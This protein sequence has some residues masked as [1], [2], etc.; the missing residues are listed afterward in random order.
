[1]L[2]VT[3]VIPCYN[4]AKFIREAIQSAL[5]QQYDG[6]LEILVG[7]DASTDDSREIAE[8][9]GGPVRV[10]CD[11]Q[12]GNRGM[13]AVRNRCIAAAS[14]PLIAF[15]DA[16][17]YWLDG[18]LRN[19]ANALEQSP[20]LGLV[21]DKGYDVSPTRQVICHRF[22]E[23]HAPR[24]TP[25]QLL[26]EQCFVPAAVMVRRSVFARVGLFDESLRNCAD[27]DMWLRVL[28]AFP[29]AHVPFYGYCYR[30]HPDQNSLSPRLW[31]AAQRVLDKARRRYRYRSSAIRQR[32]A[33]LAYR[34]S[35]IAIREKRYVR[36]ASL[37]LKAG[38]LDP[39]RALRELGSMARRIRRETRTGNHRARQECAAR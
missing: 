36:A 25:D 10:L 24:V 6:A 14:H 21:Y 13:S 19:L 15:L 39:L 1:M 17:D 38:V 34:F 9:I 26:L 30:C 27:H 16:D 23:P 22:P 32:S 12:G 7:E 29:A 37:L 31:T 18:H 20:E 33:V 28:E 5:D 4:A 11:P 8:S 2:G 3:V 35:Q